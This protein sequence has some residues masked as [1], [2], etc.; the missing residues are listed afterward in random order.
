MIFFLF[1]LAKTEIEDKDTHWRH[2]I[3][4]WCEVM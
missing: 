4:W 1:Y 2:A 3:Y